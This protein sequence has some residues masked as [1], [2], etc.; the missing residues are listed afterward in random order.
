MCHKERICS[1]TEGRIDS[2]DEKFSKV[3][4]TSS[5][6]LF[7]CTTNIYKWVFPAT[8]AMSDLFCKEPMI[9]S[10]MSLLNLTQETV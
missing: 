1:Q 10:M 8:Q 2:Q 4:L 6:Y 5:L 3:I 9:V 7:I